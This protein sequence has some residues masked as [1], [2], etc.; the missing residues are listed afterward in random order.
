[1]HAN[2]CRILYANIC[3]IHYVKFMMKKYDRTTGQ[4]LG[5]LVGSPFGLNSND[6][7]F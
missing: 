1:M 4:E 5:L 6:G 7:N 2:I 3:R